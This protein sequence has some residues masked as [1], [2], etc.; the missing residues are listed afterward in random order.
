MAGLLNARALLNL[1]SCL[2]PSDVQPGHDLCQQGED[3]DCFW[4]L[5]EGMALCCLI[6]I[7]ASQRALAEFLHS[8]ACTVLAMNHQRDMVRITAP[9]VLGEAAL[10]RGTVPA[11]R[12]RPFTF[13]CALH[14]ALSE[15]D[16]FSKS[17]LLL[18]QGHQFL[19][20]LGGISGGC[21]HF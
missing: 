1:S 3:A 12:E 8:H 20:R 13:R 15:P 6:F 17:L 21:A 4:F 16:G 18:A 5:T 10:L 19:L 7:H 2:V 11:A 14:M 9:A